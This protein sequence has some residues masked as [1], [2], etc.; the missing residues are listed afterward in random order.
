[1]AS[2]SNSSGKT[3]SVTES[4]ASRKSKP[5][6]YVVNQPVTPSRISW[7]KQQSKHVAAVSIQRLDSKN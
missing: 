3:N 2:H 6:T 4:T 5:K 7:L 1:M